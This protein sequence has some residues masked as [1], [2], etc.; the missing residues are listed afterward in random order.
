MC[1]GLITE[2][3]ISA[4]QLQKQQV[5]DAVATSSLGHLQPLH[6]HPNRS[7]RMLHET[8]EFVAQS[9]QVLP[10]KLTTRINI[11]VPDASFDSVRAPTFHGTC[12]LCIGRPLCL[13]CIHNHHSRNRNDF[14]EICS[15]TVRMCVGAVKC[16]LD[17]K[18]KIAHATRKKLPPK[19]H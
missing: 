1:R 16:G 3:R 9:T 2:L 18:T 10:Y 14:S 5:G 11:M 15:C 8:L 19:K 7:L 6:V 4:K 12:P 17:L 13:T